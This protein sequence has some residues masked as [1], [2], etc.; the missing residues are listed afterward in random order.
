MKILVALI[1]ITALNGCTKKE[2]GNTEM[3]TPLVVKVGISARDYKQVN[4]DNHINKQPMGVNFHKKHWS[5]NAR[6]TVLV[7]HGAYSLTLENVLHSTGTEDT[8]RPNSGIYKFEINGGL[9]KESTILHDEAR[10]RLTALT[11]N[12]LENGWMPYIHYNDPR[13][14]PEQGYKYYREEDDYYNIPP[15]YELSLDEWMSLKK[16]KW[17]FYADGVFLEIPLRRDSKRMVAD[18]PGAYLIAYSLYGNETHAHNQFDSDDMYNW[19]EL[20]VKK[21]GRLKSER[22]KIEASL[23]EK[24]YQIFTDYQEPVVHE[25]DPVAAAE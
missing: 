10:K 11:H 8:D 24:G 17:H 15:A 13:L 23:E 20:W 14:S 16:M 6:G 12:L 1:A 7:D 2:Q 9:A 5:S 19:R 3:A 22:A 21:I 18:E 25:A 4:G